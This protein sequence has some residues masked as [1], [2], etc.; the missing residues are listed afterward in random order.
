[1]RDEEN[2][3]RMLKTNRKARDRAY[4]YIR[5]SLRTSLTY[6]ALSSPCP[7]SGHV[8]Q[9]YPAREL[10]V[11]RQ[12]EFDEI[13]AQLKNPPS[14]AQRR[15]FAHVCERV[16]QELPSRGSKGAKRIVEMVVNRI[17]DEIQVHARGVSSQVLPGTEPVQSGELVPPLEIPIEDDEDDVTLL[18]SLPTHASIIDLARL[19]P[20]DRTNNRNDETHTAAP[21]ASSESLVGRTR[22]VPTYR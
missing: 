10:C 9:S 20:Q 17:F 1:M 15:I 4:G 19:E 21:E 22:R 7:E 16:D 8:M 11:K 14:E 13:A 5:L 6:R 3:R 2:D 18:S 12:H